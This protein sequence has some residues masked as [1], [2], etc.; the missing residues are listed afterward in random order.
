[1]RPQIKSPPR[2]GTADGLQKI[3]GGQSQTQYTTKA[4]MPIWIGDYLADTQWL[5]TEQHGAYLLLIFTYWRQGPLPDDDVALAQIVG[6]PESRWKKHRPTIARFFRVDAGQWHHKRIDREIDQAREHKAKMVE[7][8][9]K[10][11]EARWGQGGQ[12]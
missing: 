5:T 8:A 2:K 10:A 3:T 4:W 7:R 9:K 1:M 6:L 11:A 12:S